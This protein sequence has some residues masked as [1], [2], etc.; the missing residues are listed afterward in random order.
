M[1]RTGSIAMRL[2]RSGSTSKTIVATPAKE[3]TSMAFVDRKSGF[4]T[5][6]T[7]RVEQTVSQATWMDTFKTV[8]GVLVTK[9]E[10]GMKWL[11]C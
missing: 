1:E 2:Q 11:R 8:C 4:E 7:S 9:L 10:K 3:D 5:T 6:T